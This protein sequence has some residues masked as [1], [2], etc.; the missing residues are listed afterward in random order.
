M[1]ALFGAIENL[2][3]IK[4]TELNRFEPIGTHSLQKTNEN[5]N[6]AL[7]ICNKF[8]SIEEKYNLV[9]F[10]FILK[11]RYLRRFFRIL[12]LKIQGITGN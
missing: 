9:N 10:L 11:I 6:E 7:D 8:I 4:D 3:E 1:D 12:V 5:L 2:V